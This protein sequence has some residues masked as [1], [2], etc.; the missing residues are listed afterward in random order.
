MTKALHCG[1]AAS[2]GL[3][4]A[5]L[6]AR[7]FTA[8]PD[9]IG[10]PRGFAAAFF[11]ERFDPAILVAERP[12]AHIVDPGPAFKLYP[13]QYG[14]HFA[15]C[16]AGDARARLPAGASIAKVRITSPPMPYVDRP[17]PASGLAGKFSFQYA[18]AVAL[19]DGEVTVDSFTDARRFTPDVEAL[20]RRIELVP[21]PSRQGRFSRM[22]LDFVVECEDGTIIATRCDGPPGIWGR[23]A[24]PEALRSKAQTCLKAALGASRGVQVLALA[25][26][27]A[28]FRHGDLT[29]LMRLL[30]EADPPSSE[31]AA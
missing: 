30:A 13:S 25:S 12:T 8:D 26:A 21:D 29:A 19:L 31:A 28:E 10:S 9:A 1:E 7:G 3:D 5:L 17:A 6:A 14:T 4:A 24:S 20:L 22:A 23:P 18:A 16:A 2:A 27:V 15:I 11:R